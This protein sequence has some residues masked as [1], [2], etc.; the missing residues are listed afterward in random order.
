M[1]GPSARAQDPDRDRRDRRD[2]DRDDRDRDRRGND[3]YRV[4]QDR[5]YQDGLS[6]GASDA[7]QGQSYNP[8]RSHYYKNATYGY[9]SS[10]GNKNAYKRAYREGFVRGYEEGYRRNRGYNN[11]GRDRRRDRDR[12]YPFSLR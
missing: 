1:S 6:T 3:S 4:A 10:Y 12:R 11:G 9:D 5:G 7:N 2:R 8:Q